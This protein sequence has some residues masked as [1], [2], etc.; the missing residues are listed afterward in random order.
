[1]KAYKRNDGVLVQVDQCDFGDGVTV[2]CLVDFVRWNLKEN[3]ATVFEITDRKPWFRAASPD[4]TLMHIKKDESGVDMF[5]RLLDVRFNL[6]ALVACVSDLTSTFAT[7]DDSNPDKSASGASGIIELRHKVE[8][9]ILAPVIA[10]QNCALDK[11]A[12]QRRSVVAYPPA[13]TDLLDEINV[14]C[15]GRHHPRVYHQTRMIGSSPYLDWYQ[16]FQTIGIGL[17]MTKKED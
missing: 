17:F 16:R 1:M 15:G 4:E 13:V 8:E 14:S 2:E 3:G 10:L 12:E 9:R 5:R 7:T 6:N 11:V